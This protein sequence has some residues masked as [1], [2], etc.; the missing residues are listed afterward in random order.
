MFK[1][2]RAVFACAIVV[3]A[4]LPAS[5]LAWD[6]GKIKS[7]S[8]PEIHFYAPPETG[9][10]RVEA[11]EG[12]AQSPQQLAGKTILYSVDVQGSWFGQVVGGFYL[13]DNASHTVT[14]VIGNAANIADGFQYYT[15]VMTNCAAPK[16]TPTPGPAGPAGPQGP[17]G[18]A[19][20]PGG[21][22][23]T[24]T[25]T[26][27][28]VHQPPRTCTSRRSYRFHVRRAFEGSRVVAAKATEP[29]VKVTTR[30]RH[31]RF[32]VTWTTKGKRYPAGGVIRS[33]TVHA[34][35][36]NG[37]HI[38]FVWR[39][40]PCLKNDGNLNDPPASDPSAASARSSWG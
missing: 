36:A 27:V 8:C 34:R 13:P 10:W 31:G 35:L 14:V 17:A 26:T 20:P 23:N 38:N 39:Y 6:G 25:T 30:K 5:A 33:V 2:I 4:V 22:T 19:G 9:A 32:V 3:L 11:V 24:N 29:G 16:G 28:V 18:P 37:R 21:G 15:T 40:R 7:V 1:H 12:V